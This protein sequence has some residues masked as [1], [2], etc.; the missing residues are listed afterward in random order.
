[1]PGMDERTKQIKQTVLRA[2]TLVAEHEIQQRFSSNLKILE[3]MVPDLY[4]R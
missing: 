4:Q 2:E 3:K 1:M